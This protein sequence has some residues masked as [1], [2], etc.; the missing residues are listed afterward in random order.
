[1]PKLIDGQ[2]YSV[3]FQDNITKAVEGAM[4]HTTNPISM[5]SYKKLLAGKKMDAVILLDTDDVFEAL[6]ETK[7]GTFTLPSV[8]IKRVENV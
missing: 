6:V 7:S 5:M 4:I 8:A 1:M 2:V 3:T